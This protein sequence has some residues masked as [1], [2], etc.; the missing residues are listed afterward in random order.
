MVYKGARTSCTWSRTIVILCVLFLAL[1]IAYILF[2]SAN[3]LYQVGGADLFASMR[4][5]KGLEDAKKVELAAALSKRP[6]NLVF[7]FDIRPKDQGGLIYEF[8]WIR[9]MILGG[10]NRPV[11]TWVSSPSTRAQKMNDSLLVFLFKPKGGSG[12]FNEMR[13]EGYTNLGA[14][15]MGNELFD[16]DTS[17]YKDLDYVFYNYY[18]VELLRREP[19]STYIPL[20]LKAGFCQVNPTTLVP[21]NERRHVCSFMGSIRSNRQMMLD[22]FAAANLSCVLSIDK[23]WGDPTQLT[24]IEYRAVLLESTFALAPWGNNPETLRMYEALE[25]GAIPIYQ[26][27]S[28]IEAN[29][30]FVLHGLPNWPGLIVNSWEEATLLIPL[31]LQDKK[32]ILQLQADVI[33]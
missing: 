21:S 15:H 30:D 8:D 24:T 7:E 32:L 26:N 9:H 18:D 13:Q 23:E 6:L 31:Y 2:S 28:I 11:R 1:P 3:H 12:Y 29:R 33:N 19:K 16:Q 10:V 20:G 25:A 22:A 4:L 14:Y 17:F 27:Y 5:S